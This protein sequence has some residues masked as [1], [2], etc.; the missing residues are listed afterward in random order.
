MAVLDRNKIYEIYMKDF[1]PFKSAQELVNPNFTATEDSIKAS[2]EQTIKRFETLIPEVKLTE[3]EKTYVI[4]KIKAVHSI[5][6][7]EGYVILGDYEHDYDWYQ[8]FLNS[9]NA[10]TY[11]WDRYKNYL[12]T[13]KHFPKE[14][15]NV[16]EN[17]TLFSLMS[18]LGNPK[19]SSSFSVRGLV[20]GDVQSGKTSNYLGLLT[21]AADS[22]YKV[23]FIL[24]GTIESLRKQTQQRVEEGFIGWDS[25]NGV[26][27]GVGRGDPTPK[28]FT[29]RAK[30]FVGTD[31]QNTTYK[32]SNLVLEYK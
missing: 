28:A 9:E 3:E 29:S 30:D 2:I 11:Y 16:L 21:K 17:K 26:A 22:G 20:V 14:V 13:T 19:D 10:Q 5:Y 15:I 23:I 25:F 32:L 12:E 4:N 7:E 24:T 27:V 1:A 6:Q 18:Y 8:N 31:D